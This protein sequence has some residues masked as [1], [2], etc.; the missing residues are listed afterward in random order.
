MDPHEPEDDK[1]S[2]SRAGASPATAQQVAALLMMIAVKR[3]AKRARPRRLARLEQVGSLL[4][5]LIGGVVGNVLEWYDFAVFGYFAPMIG[6]QFFPADD[7]LDSLLGAFSVFAAAYLVRPDRGRHLRL[8]RRPARPQASP[9]ALGD[10]DGRCRRVSSASCPPRP[11][12]A[13]PRRVLLVLLR[14]AQGLS[15][16]G[17]LIGSIAFVAETAPAAAPG[18]LLAAG[19]SRAAT[20]A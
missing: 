16:G 11:R 12:S 10:D 3:E 5:N 13:R 14:I 20:A 19:P 4:K 7:P 18:L 6:A 2:E 1:P 17:E 15:V 8:D 9:P